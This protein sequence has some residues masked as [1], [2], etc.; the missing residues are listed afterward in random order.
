MSD[1]I[2]GTVKWFDT[3]KGYG[4]IQREGGSDIFV[5]YSAVQGGGF[6]NLYEGQQVEMSIEQGPRGLQ[7]SQVKPL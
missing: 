1:R 2:I 6:K 5:H 4:F 7:A 3:K